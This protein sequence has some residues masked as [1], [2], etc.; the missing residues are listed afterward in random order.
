MS[1]LQRAGDLRAED[2]DRRRQE[3]RN[4]DTAERPNVKTNARA[5][6]CDG[7]RTRSEDEGTCAAMILKL[8]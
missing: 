5:S 7:T 3:N 8:Q 2:P 4:T 1:V 6:S